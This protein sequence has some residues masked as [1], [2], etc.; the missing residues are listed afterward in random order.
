VEI[1]YRCADGDLAAFADLHLQKPAVDSRV[2]RSVLYGYAGFV[3]LLA[4]LYF[5]FGPVEFAIV[6]LLVGPIVIAV[7]PT[8]LRWFYGKRVLAAARALNGAGPDDPV[9]LRLD[10]AG[11]ARIT[12]KGDDRFQVLEIVELPEHVLIFVG[13]AR[14]FVIARQQVVRGDAAAFAAAARQRRS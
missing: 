12:P 4:W 9:L 2:R 8:G 5:R 14:A 3:L 7:W 11:L 13:P 1:E 10:G 6:L